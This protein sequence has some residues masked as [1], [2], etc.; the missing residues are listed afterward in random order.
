A[1]YSVTQQNPINVFSV[2]KAPKE[3][4]IPGWIEGTVKPGD[5][6]AFL[7]DVVTSG[8]SVIDAL[9]HCQEY[10]LKVVQVLLLVD[11]QEQGGLQKIKD[12]VGP[13]VPVE[14]IFSFSKLQEFWK[15]YNASDT[16]PVSAPSRY[17]A[18][19]TPATV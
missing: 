17:A 19:G 3:H 7:D 12:A 11:R 4:G 8:N 1:Y 10:G 15:E 6:V 9:K 14:A 18:A 13:D 16:K 5:T 2:R